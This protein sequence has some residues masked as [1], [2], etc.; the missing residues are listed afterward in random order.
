MDG[1]LTRQTVAKVKEILN[2]PHR[3]EEMVNTNFNI[4]S[5]H[6]SYRVLRRWLN[7][8]LINFFGTEI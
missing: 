7:T 3:R 1:F 2:S 4:A 6:Y 5:Q 8:L